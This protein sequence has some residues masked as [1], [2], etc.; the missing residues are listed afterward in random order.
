MS[1]SN[2]VTLINSQDAKEKLL[3]EFGTE[4]SGWN[5]TCQLFAPDGPDNVSFDPPILISAAL[6]KHPDVD[7]N[8]YLV[9][10]F[11]VAGNESAIIREFEAGDPVAEA[12][13]SRLQSVL[14]SL[15]F[16]LQDIFHA[17]NASAAPFIPISGV[18][19]PSLPANVPQPAPAIP[20]P[21][22]PS[23]PPVTETHATV[24]TI[25]EAE[26]ET[27]TQVEA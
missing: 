10:N 6:H 18:V 24:S 5:E 17:Q 15:A 3:D 16:T 20:A 8:D 27:A 25:P 12:N 7:K 21:E 23:A 2:K 22:Q 4:G 1:A 14:Q 13:F 9:V 19:P 11:D 26:P